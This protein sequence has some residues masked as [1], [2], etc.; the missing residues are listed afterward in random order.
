MA[1]A[2]G[3][4]E[5]SAD[6]P[7][8]LPS[9]RTRTKFTGWIVPTLRQ[10]RRARLWRTYDAGEAVGGA[11]DAE[12]RQLTAPGARLDPNAVRWDVI[13]TATSGRRCRI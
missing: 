6:V 10:V 7:S 11:C 9:S 1:V 4:N 2:S 5:L 3:R 13:G 12:I 8:V